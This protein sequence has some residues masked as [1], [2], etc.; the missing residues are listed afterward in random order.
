M[1]S[2]GSNPPQRGAL[3]GLALRTAAGV[4]VGVAAVVLTVMCGGAVILTLH[5][6]GAAPLALIPITIAVAFLLGGAVARLVAGHTRRRGWVGA[7][8][9]LVTLLALAV[10]PEHG[11]VWTTPAAPDALIGPGPGATQVHSFTGLV[12]LFVVVVGLGTAWLGDLWACRATR[13]GPQ[14][15]T[16]GL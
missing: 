13:R 1:T 7:T 9:T 6:P 11:W 10:A 4:V 2:E 8:C 12:W 15:A 14:V 3:L 5:P 16:P